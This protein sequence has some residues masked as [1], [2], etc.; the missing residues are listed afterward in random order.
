MLSDVQT[1]WA[2]DALWTSNGRLY[3]V[4]LSIENL[5]RPE[6]DQVVSIM[7][8]HL[9]PL[10]DVQL[11]SIYDHFNEDMFASTYAQRYLDSFTLKFYVKR[12]LNISL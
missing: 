3:N 2:S 9:I 1:Q 12:I 8:V 7:D 4:R 10:L 6:D 11:T 5:V